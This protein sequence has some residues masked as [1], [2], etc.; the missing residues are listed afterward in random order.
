MKTLLKIY[1]FYGLAVFAL[2]F[3]L[4]LPFFL[5]AIFVKPFEKSAGL[6]NHIWAR[7]LIFFLFLHRS[8]T[9]YETKLERKQTYVFCANHFSYLDIP[10]MGLINHNF[11][12]IGKSSLK[13]VPLWGYM[14]SKLHVL[15]DRES[16]RGKHASWV[17]AKEAIQNG[18]SMAFFPEGGI[19]TK[20]A[21][22]MARFKEGCFRIAVEEQIPVVPVTI[23]NNHLIL[24]DGLPLV[25]RPG[26]VSIKIHTPIWP[27]GTDDAAVNHLKN[28]AAKVIQN[29][30][31]RAHNASR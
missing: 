5:L 10:T 18:F 28:T 17:Q 23:H 31:N 15:V 6:L 12:F 25:V 14:Y 24:P 7:L 3:V 29:E 26:T 8:N 19:Y 4:L 27:Q 16:L 13:K 22:Q 30:L 1:S 21:P 2:V 11:K 20:Q 9:V